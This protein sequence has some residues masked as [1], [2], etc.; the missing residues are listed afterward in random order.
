M[1]KTMEEFITIAVQFF[2][3]NPKRVIA[4]STSVPTVGE[5]VMIRAGE[6]A[7]HAIVFKLPTFIE[8]QFVENGEDLEREIK[9]H[10]KK[11]H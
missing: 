11:M 1:N 3:K 4:A 6:N 2:L 10:R 9:K 8:I 7:K 5:Y